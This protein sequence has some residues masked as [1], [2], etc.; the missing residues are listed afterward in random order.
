MQ[1]HLIN[2]N[3][4][5]LATVSSDGNPWNTPLFFAHQ[6]ETIYWWSPL[7]AV[8]S[9]NIINN[10]NAFI[11]IYDSTT[12]IGKGDGVCLYLECE[13]AM[14]DDENERNKAIKLFN[15]KVGDKDFYLNKGNTTGD[16]PTRLF[17]ANILK[18][19]LNAEGEKN[20]YFVDTRKPF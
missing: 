13:A 6:H 8:H 10:G 3:Y 17:K 20:G 1:E 7:D 19:W 9:L 11:T 14:V 16:S 2:N 18:S 5:N 4:C 12:P 15:N